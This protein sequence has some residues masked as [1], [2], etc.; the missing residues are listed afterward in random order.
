M[1][2]LVGS[3]CTTNHAPVNKNPQTGLGAQTH[4]WADVGELEALL[5]EVWVMSADLNP[6][7]ASGAWL[8][9]LWDM[10]PLAFH[11]ELGAG[12]SQRLASLHSGFVL[13]SGFVAS[14]L[15]LGPVPSPSPAASSSIFPWLPRGSLS[16]SWSG[17]AAGVLEA[18]CV[19]L[20]ALKGLVLTLAL[21]LICCM[22][23]G[24]S[25]PCSVP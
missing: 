13:L 24:K 23:L 19:W 25:L 17:E 5:A 10:F 21:P 4:R 11:S 16:L 9:G 18:C 1:G 7:V 22:A 14:D 8:A 2:P 12:T 15:D 3:Q 6:N 20:R